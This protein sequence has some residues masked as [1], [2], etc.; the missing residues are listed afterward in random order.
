VTK[1]E[2]VE[3]KETNSGTRPIT[4]TATGRIRLGVAEVALGVL[5]GTASSCAGMLA[6]FELIV[7]AGDATS[8]VLDPTIA[9]PMLV[10]SGFGLL[11]GT[12]LA[13]IGWRLVRRQLV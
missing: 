4:A 5:T 1:V 8:V 12:L 9:I 11:G 13:L 7:P 3:N 2:D 6:L 10:G